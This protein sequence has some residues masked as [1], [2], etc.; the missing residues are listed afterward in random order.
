MVDQKCLEK[1]SIPLRPEQI[2]NTINY[3][4]PFPLDEEPPRKK[5]R[6]KKALPKNVN[7]PAIHIYQ[8]PVKSCGREH[9]AIR[10]EEEWAQTEDGGAIQSF[11]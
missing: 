11:M 6:G 2:K 9:T 1:L 7:K 4:S 8:C 10:K 5:T 3:I